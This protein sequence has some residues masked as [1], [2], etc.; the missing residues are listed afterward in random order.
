[1]GKIITLILKDPFDQLQAK[2]IEISFSFLQKGTQKETNSF[3]SENFCFCSCLVPRVPRVPP[4]A[5]DENFILSHIYFQKDSNLTKFLTDDCLTAKYSS[6]WR[7]RCILILPYIIPWLGPFSVKK[8]IFCYLGKM[9]A[10]EIPQSVFL[11]AA[12]NLRNFQHIEATR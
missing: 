1:M 4:N 3:F 11:A 7:P 2:D 12:E 10:Y 9:L 5:C 8:S 6:V